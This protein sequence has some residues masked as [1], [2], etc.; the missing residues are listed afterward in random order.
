MHADTSLGVTGGILTITRSYEGLEA[1]DI[2]IAGGVISLFATDDGLNAAGGNDGSAMGGRPGQGNFTGGV[3]TLSIT[4]GYLVMDAAGDGL[5]SNGTLTVTGGVTLVSGPTNSGNGAL[6]YG[7]AASVSGGVVVAL[8]AAGMATG[9]TAAEN[10]GA[11]LTTLSPGVGGQSFALCDSDGNVIV[12]F[13][14]SKSYSSAVI[15]APGIRDNGSYTIVVG[16]I[17][18]GADENGYAQNT[19]L[20]G[21]TT[22]AEIKMDGYLYGSSGMG[23]MGGMPGMP[24]GGMGGGMRPG[25]PGW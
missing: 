20:T 7:S 19:T 23:G 25:R 1:T 11:I 21:G 8:G 12:S 10:Q 13:T 6:D 22:V 9:F 14:P 16:G 3:G 2:V 15:T 4:G 5:D 17:V 18:A 24:G